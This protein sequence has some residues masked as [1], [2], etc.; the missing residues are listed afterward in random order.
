MC[1]LGTRAARGH[2]WTG[3]GCG[4]YS[5]ETEL[6]PVCKGPRIGERT[7]A[8]GQTLKSS[9]ILTS[10]ATCGHWCCI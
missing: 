1:T 6:L 3:A 5:H 7:E 10:S 2:I 9:R 4:V 8:A